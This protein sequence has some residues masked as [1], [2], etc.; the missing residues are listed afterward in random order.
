MDTLERLSPAPLS[1]YDCK[2]ICLIK[3]SS[4]GDV[5]QA[6]PILAMLRYRFPISRISWV[7]NREYAPL[8]RPIAELDEVIEFDRSGYKAG[9]PSSWLRFRKFLNSLTDRQFELTVD[10]QGLLRSGL[11]TLATKAPVRI[12]LR[13]AREGAG[14]FYTHVAD[15]TGQ[16]GAV[17]RY[18]SVASI[19]GAQNVP[20]S[21]PLGLNA[22]EHRWALQQLA[23]CARPWLAVNPGARWMTK[24]WPAERFADVA[25]R[26]LLEAGGGTVLLLGGPG[27]EGIA[28]ECRKHLTVPIRDFCGSTSLRELAALLSQ[29]DM[30][31]TNDTGPM[32]LAAAVGTPTVSLFTCT[33]PERAA[34]FGD[35]HTTIQTTVPCKASYLRDCSRM[36]CMR[37]LTVDR[38][39]PVVTTCLCQ[40]ARLPQAEA[41]QSHHQA[42]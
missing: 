24:R 21:F 13:T 1:G 27:E 17:D 23:G 20:K 42:A 19:L 7:V 31:L 3:P 35:N 36:D 41:S 10:L 22:Q 30:L 6:L 40:H 9:Q 4:L 8:L 25:N 12:G 28:A 2:R 18:W 33:S 5:V 15:D 26:T 11:M 29:C 37:D 16:Q 32:H 39:L 34:P 14:F 38:V